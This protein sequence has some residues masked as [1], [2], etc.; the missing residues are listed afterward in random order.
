MT[1]W[2]FLQSVLTV[3]SW[4]ALYGAIMWT[5]AW[6]SHLVMFLGKMF[7]KEAYKVP[8]NCALVAT[9]SWVVFYICRNLMALNLIGK[10]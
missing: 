1:L 3:V 9:L 4:F 2:V 6:F 8:S 10:F 5:M 7:N